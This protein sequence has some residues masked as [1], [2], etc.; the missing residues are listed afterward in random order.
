MTTIYT[1]QNKKD[2]KVTHVQCLVQGLT[3]L[4]TTHL[5]QYPHLESSCELLDKDNKQVREYPFSAP[6]TL[7]LILISPSERLALV[8]KHVVTNPFQK[9]LLLIIATLYNLVKHII[10]QTLLKPH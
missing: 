1:G 7:Q 10:I 3:N 9:M 8:L 4:E 6:S 2:V 5:D